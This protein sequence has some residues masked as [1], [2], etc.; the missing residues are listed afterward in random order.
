MIDGEPTSEVVRIASEVL[1]ASFNIE[2]LKERKGNAKA[3]GETI[4]N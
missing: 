2:L 1:R 3:P 4:Q